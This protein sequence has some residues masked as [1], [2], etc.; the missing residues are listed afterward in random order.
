MP[1]Q[2]SPGEGEGAKEGK[3][4][5]A[6]RHVMSVKV[7]FLT[8]IKTCTSLSCSYY[9]YLI[10]LIAPRES[11]I[12]MSGDVDLLQITLSWESCIELR[13]MHYTE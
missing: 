5:G 4:P 12:G 11:S 7:R 8:E 10:V 1:E 13:E 9:Y 2:G 3:S 6:H